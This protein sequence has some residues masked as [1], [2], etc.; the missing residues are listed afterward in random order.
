MKSNLY[1]TIQEDLK[2]KIESGVFE[3]NQKL[4]SEEELCGHYSVSKVTLRKAL[5]LLID[6]GYLQAKSRVGYF[7]KIPEN[8]NFVIQ[9]DAEYASTSPV[10][11]ED[12]VRASATEQIG[13]D[14]N[15]YYQVEV[16]RRMYSNGM[17]AAVE[18]CSVWM[19]HGMSAASSGAASGEALLRRQQKVFSNI[20]YYT[21]RK[22]MKIRALTGSEELCEWLDCFEDDPLL[23][24]EVRYYD[25]YG[26][27]FAQTETYYAGEY[28]VLRAEINR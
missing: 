28:G 7:V 26:I 19:H 18:A 21:E 6:E 2:N 24:V 5:S 22:E 20:H 25:K 1:K 13:A 12:V 11:R 27:L 15:A 8:N 23:C 3:Q 16:V 10:D 4:P 9:F 14:K 17:V